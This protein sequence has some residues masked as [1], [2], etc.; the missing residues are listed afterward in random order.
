VLHVIEEAGWT[1]EVKGSDSVEAEPQEAI[2]ACKMIHVGVGNE[3]GIRKGIIDA[4]QGQ[5][6]N[7]LDFISAEAQTRVD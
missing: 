4:H 5:C 7:S 6:G 1:D 2:E 3:R